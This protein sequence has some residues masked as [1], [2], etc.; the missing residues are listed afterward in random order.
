MDLENIR[1]NAYDFFYSKYY[2]V[3]KLNE[4]IPFSKHK[5]YCDKVFDK[6]VEYVD[7]VYENEYHSDITNRL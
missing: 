4:I 3:N 7:K 1:V 2:N 5:E 6:I